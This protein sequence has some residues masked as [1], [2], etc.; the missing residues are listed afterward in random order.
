ML[1]PRRVGGVVELT[2]VHARSP[3][4]AACVR[5]RHWLQRERHTNSITRVNATGSRA[6]GC[7]V[8]IACTPTPGR[9]TTALARADVARAMS[10]AHPV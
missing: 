3:S 9:V 7:I 5:R 4:G 1:C 8:P 10:I 2:A 6:V